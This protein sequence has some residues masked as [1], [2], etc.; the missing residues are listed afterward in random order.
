MNEW[1][2]Q[3]AEKLNSEVKNVTGRKEMVMRDEVKNALLEFCRQDEEFAQAV[4]Q[5]GS[6]PDCLKT[7][8][9]ALTGKD[10]CSDLAAYRKAV[11]FYF[12]GADIQM[13][14]RINLCASVEGTPAA[15]VETEN[16]PRPGGNGITL[17]LSDFLL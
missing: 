14:M 8:A 12:P 7:V 1:Y 6:F 15:P 9:N 16:A 3:A 2:S 5:G 13:T 11:A 17:N 4:V 10:G